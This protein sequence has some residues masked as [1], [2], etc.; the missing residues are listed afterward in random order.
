MCACVRACARV[1]VC[2]CVR[3]CVRACVRTR[4]CVC[5]CVFSVTDYT[6]LHNIIRTNC[7]ADNNIMNRNLSDVIKATTDVTSDRATDRLL[8]T[9][10]GICV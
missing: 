10:L 3:A 4:V 1:C 9:Y 6:A 5:V 7:D 2:V 8:Q